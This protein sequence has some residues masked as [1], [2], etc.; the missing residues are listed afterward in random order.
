VLEQILNDPDTGTVKLGS[1]SDRDAV[2]IVQQALR[3]LR[4]HEVDGTFP[5]PSECP[6]CHTKPWRSAAT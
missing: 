1:G 3:D 6:Q 5:E 2:K 4:G